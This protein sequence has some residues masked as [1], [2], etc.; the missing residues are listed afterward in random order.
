MTQFCQ[1][2]QKCMQ[3]E[4]FYLYEISYFKVE[5]IPYFAVVSEAPNLMLLACQ[6]NI[7]SNWGPDSLLYFVEEAFRLS[8]LR[9]VDTDMIKK[10]PALGTF[11]PAIA[12]DYL[13]G[14]LNRRAS[15]PRELDYTWVNKERS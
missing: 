11:L 2:S 12:N 4:K 8:R 9:K 3:V 14:T 10:D 15:H 7:T 6:P 5:E 13:P 1:C